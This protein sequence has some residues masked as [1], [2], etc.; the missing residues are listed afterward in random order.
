M[1]ER[2]RTISDAARGHAGAQIVE[3]LLRLSLSWSH[4]S[5]IALFGGLKNEPDILQPLLDAFA[6]Q[7]ARLVCFQIGPD[8][9]FPC[10]IR[11]MGDLQR[12]VMNVWEPKPLCQPVGIGALDIVLVPGL[13]FTREGCR[14]GRGGGYYDRLLAHP[15]CHARRVGIACDLQII[16]AIPCEP[17]DQR[18]HQII[19]E[20]G[21]I[22]PSVPH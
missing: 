21:L 3:H 13:A 5:T 18:V 17:H 14:L 9:L 20:S 15:D 4:G 19:T 16:D 11:D 22:H 1:R 10:Q 12:G 6:R 8:G 2:L 7:G